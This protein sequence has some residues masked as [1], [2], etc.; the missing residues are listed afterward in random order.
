MSDLQAVHVAVTRLF[1]IVLLQSWPVNGTQTFAEQ[2]KQDHLDR[3]VIARPR[4]PNAV[5]P[6][7][8]RRNFEA[9]VVD[10]KILRVFWNIDPCLRRRTSPANNQFGTPRKRVVSTSSEE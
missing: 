7:D 10:H 8:L 3:G 6:S 9:V 4:N 1:S 5:H 2:N